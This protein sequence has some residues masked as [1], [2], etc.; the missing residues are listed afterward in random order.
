MLRLINCRH[1]TLLLEQ[2]QDPTLPRRE[3][4]SLWL[5]LHICRYC[6]RYSQQTLLIAEWARASAT[7]RAQ[8]GPALS[9][10]AKERMRERLVAAG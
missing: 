5:H 1:A 9:E 6:K 8:A 10:A 7:A 2:R 3:R 4:A